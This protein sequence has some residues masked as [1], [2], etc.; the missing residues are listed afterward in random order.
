MREIEAPD[1]LAPCFSFDDDYVTS[2]DALFEFGEVWGVADEFFS[3][4]VAVSV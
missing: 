4:F 2:F 3:C 1:M